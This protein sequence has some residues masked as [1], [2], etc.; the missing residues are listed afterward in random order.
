MKEQDCQVIDR[1]GRSV[2]AGVQLPSQFNPA[3]A[4]RIQ[5]LDACFG[6][7]LAALKKTGLYDNSIII[8]TSDHGDSLGE[9]GR[10]GHAY[11][12]FPEIVRIP[13]IV[14]LPAWMQADVKFDPN[15]VA[16]LTDVT[17]SLYYLLGQK[18]TAND[19]LFGRPLFTATL[20]EQ[21]PYHRDSYLLASSYA[22]VY[23]LLTDSGRSLY[24][25]DGV[26]Y[27]DYAYQLNPDGASHEAPLTEAE[28]TASQDA[29]QRQIEAIARFYHLQ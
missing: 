4:S 3:Y 19:S 22:P 23:G 11:T 1:E 6:E 26:N 15:S 20:A 27:R 16:F 17:P 28:R 14:H 24:I 21:Q 18:P 25:A 29:I 7:F 10:W 12:L 2:P 5:K 13:L 9:N 8:L